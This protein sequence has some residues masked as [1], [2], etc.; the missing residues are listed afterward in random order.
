M[1]PEEVFALIDKKAQGKTCDAIVGITEEGAEIMKGRVRKD[2]TRFW[3]LAVVDAIRDENG[4]VIGFAKV[5]RDMTERMF[6]LA[7]MRRE[8]Q[9]RPF[10]TPASS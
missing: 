2:A 1:L 6:R 3:A 7:K 9:P 4:E 8:D 10:S 5:T